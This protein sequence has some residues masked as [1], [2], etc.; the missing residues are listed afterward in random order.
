MFCRTCLYDLRSSA[1]R[2]PECGREFDRVDA[3]TVYEYPF[4]RWRV[5]WFKVVIAFDRTWV[6]ALLT[7]A[8]TAAAAFAP[9]AWYYRAEFAAFAAL[10][11]ANLVRRHRQG[12]TLARWLADTANKGRPSP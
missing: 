12:P 8:C 1:D 6:Y 7:V 5:L 9:T 11:A 10:N 2:C 3:S 4:R